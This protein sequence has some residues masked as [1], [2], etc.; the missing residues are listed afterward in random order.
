MKQKKLKKKSKAVKKKKKSKALDL[1]PNTK[2]LT[3]DISVLEEAFEGDKKNGFVFSGLD[4][5]QSKRD[6][7]L[8]KN[9]TQKP[10]I[11]SPE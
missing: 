5:K 7:K 6:G 1:M 3:T 9:S 11:Q 2:S 10:A 4:E 8:F